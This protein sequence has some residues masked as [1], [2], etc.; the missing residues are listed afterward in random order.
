M[1]LI[2]CPACQRHV[3]AE[4]PACPFCARSLG[5]TRR[6]VGGALGLVAAA[7]LAGCPEAS[8]SS[9]PPGP[10][11]PAYG[12]PPPMVQP[13]D[14]PTEQPTE[15]PIDQEGPA[16]VYGAP[17]PPDVAPVASPDPGPPAPVYGGPPVEPDGPPTP[18]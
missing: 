15:Q 18:R 11:V 16:D 12:G 5:P 4:E 7:A 14:Q 8:T 9:P 6:A 1:S 2:P 10:P 17:P 3:R 13:I